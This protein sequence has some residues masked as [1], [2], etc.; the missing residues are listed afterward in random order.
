MAHLSPK[1]SGARTP[2]HLLQ[3]NR[4][5]AWI[6]AYWLAIDL[7]P[8]VGSSGECIPAAGDVLLQAAGAADQTC[9]RHSSVLWL[10]ANSN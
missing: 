7:A 10:P 8:G 4:I 1:F 3:S 6:G 9:S 2:I 5:R